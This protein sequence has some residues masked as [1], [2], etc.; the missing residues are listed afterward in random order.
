MFIIYYLFRC[1]TQSV[2]VMFPFPVDEKVGPSLIFN[3]GGDNASRRTAAASCRCCRT[4]FV[5]NYQRS[6]LRM[7]S[8]NRGRHQLLRWR[9]PLKLIHISPADLKRITCVSAGAARRSMHRFV[10]R[11]PRRNHPSSAPRPK[12]NSHRRNHQHRF[13]VR[14]GHVGNADGW[15]GSGEAAGLFWFRSGSDLG[16]V[17]TVP[18]LRWVQQSTLDSASTSFD[19]SSLLHGF[20]LLF[21]ETSWQ[22]LVGNSR[23]CSHLPVS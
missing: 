13:G 14:G 5:I 7:F 12:I 22:T 2:P 9:R 16:P 23:G 4:P 17:G 1:L 18:V 10:P 21:L 8:V 15:R 3:G 11:G 6:S 19:L 20:N